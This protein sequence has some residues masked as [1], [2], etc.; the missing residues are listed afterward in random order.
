MPPAPITLTTP[1]V[2]PCT[3]CFQKQKARGGEAFPDDFVIA[4]FS[5]LCDAVQYMHDNRVLHRDISSAN[6]FLSFYGEI[7]LG[8]LGLSRQLKNDVGLTQVRARPPTSSHLARYPARPLPLSSLRSPTH[9]LLHHR[10][11]RALTAASIPC[12]VTGCEHPGWHATLHV[13]R[14]CRR[15]R[16]RHL[17]RHMGS[18]YR[19]L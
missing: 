7:L 3:V 6:I 14:A 13:A 17:L 18:R 15:P 11:S 9:C 4:W 12:A 2:S 5:Q 1:R 19:A 10:R 8:D 16:V